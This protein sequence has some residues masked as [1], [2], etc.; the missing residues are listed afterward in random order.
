MDA[1]YGSC[2]SPP[3]YGEQDSVS[4]ERGRPHSDPHKGRRMSNGS[5]CSVYP[6]WSYY[7]EEFGYLHCRIIR[8][9]RMAYSLMRISRQRTLGNLGND[10]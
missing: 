7:A 9:C 10:A 6:G 4:Q 5:A 2:P 3:G 1:D 8:P